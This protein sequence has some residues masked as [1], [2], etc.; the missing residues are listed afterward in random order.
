MTWYS[1]ITEKIVAAINQ[2]LPEAI[3][4]RADL[5][6]PPQP[7]LGDLSWPCFA[8]AKKFGLS[9]IELAKDL[10]TKLID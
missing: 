8:A 1:K 2:E 3:A 5:L 9:P 10:A 7:E 4:D 6:V